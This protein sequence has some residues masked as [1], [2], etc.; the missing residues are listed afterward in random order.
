ML[1]ALVVQ[2]DPERLDELLPAK[3]NRRYR[4]VAMVERNIKA[5]SL[6]LQGVSERAI[7]QQLGMK[8]QT[9]ARNAI[10]RGEQHAK[11]LGLDT[12]RIRLRIAAAFEEL[13]MMGLAD[14]RKQVTEGRV[15]VIQNPDGTT[16]VKTAKGVDSRSLGE[17]GRGL[18][19]MA[20][21]AGL[22]DGDAGGSGNGNTTL[23]SLNMPADGATLE[24]KWATADG[25]AA[26]AAAVDVEAAA[27][28]EP[29]V[30][31]LVHADAPEA[32]KSPCAQG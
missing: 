25:P 1:E 26:D 2:V 19:R 17:V 4:S 23:I 27:V 28:E 30:H 11:Q 10:K 8:S 7:G 18:V 24:S 13:T 22:M 12:E 5:F 21:F 32:G 9:T 29:A 31:A 14:L 6:S 16:T 3:I 20:Q 15:L